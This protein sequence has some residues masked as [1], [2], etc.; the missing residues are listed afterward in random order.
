MKFDTIKVLH[1]TS[2]FYLQMRI[3]TWLIGWTGQLQG[4]IQLSHPLVGPLIPFLN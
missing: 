1:I 3:H 4:D 2:F